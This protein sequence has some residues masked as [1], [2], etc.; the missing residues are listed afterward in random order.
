MLHFCRPPA[1]WPR[2][3]RFDSANRQAFQ[4]LLQRFRP[5]SNLLLVFLAS[6]IS[7]VGLT[8]PL[9]IAVARHYLLARSLGLDWMGG[10]HDVPAGVVILTGANACPECGSTRSTGIRKSCVCVVMAVRM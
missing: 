4:I 2:P 6:G 5:L 8:S 1:R 10:R 7:G 3:C 9:V